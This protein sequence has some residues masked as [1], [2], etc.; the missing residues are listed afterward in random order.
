MISDGSKV[1]F[2]QP[3]PASRVSPPQPDEGAKR[4]LSTEGKTVQRNQTV[5][6]TTEE[7]AAHDAASEVLARWSADRP[8]S[9]V[10]D[11]LGRLEG[12]EAREGYYAA[13]ERDL[14]PD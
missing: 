2:T 4:E 12:K 10:W 11:Y 8:Y 5:S 7:R 13:L 6:E 14:P 3:G 1:P 9:W